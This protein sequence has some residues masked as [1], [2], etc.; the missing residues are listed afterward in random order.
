[1]SGVAELVCAAGL[2]HPATRRAAGWASVAVLLGV[3]PANVQMSLDTGRRASRRQTTT[4]RAV[5][6]GTLVRLP[7][8]WPMT[9]AAL[10]AAQG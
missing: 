4:A 9:R 6:V 2:M 7:A 10:R 8:Q 5:F 3:L 1:M